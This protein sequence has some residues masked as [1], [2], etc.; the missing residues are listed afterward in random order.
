MYEERKYTMLGSLGLLID[1]QLVLLL[2]AS[3]H[4]S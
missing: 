3:D 4:I 2:W 1:N